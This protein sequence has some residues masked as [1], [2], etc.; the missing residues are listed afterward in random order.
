[1]KLLRIAFVLVA[2]AFAAVS[3]HAQY[4][5]YEGNL[6]GKFILGGGGKKVTLNLLGAVTLEQEHNT[7]GYLLLDGS[8]NIT[9]GKLEEEIDSTITEHTGLT[10]SYTFNGLNGCDGTLTVQSSGYHRTF[11]LSGTSLNPTTKDVGSFSLLPNGGNGE[12]EVYTAEK[13]V[14]PPGGCNAEMLDNV[15]FGG[16]IDGGTGG[17]T[18]KGRFRTTF[19]NTVSGATVSVTEID[20]V[21]GTLQPTAT[22]TYPAFVNFDCSVEIYSDTSYSNKIGEAQLGASPT[23]SATSEAIKPAISPAASPAVPW[24]S[25]YWEEREGKWGKGNYQD[26]IL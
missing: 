26:W 20:I 12:D 17:N 5:C 23:S 3:A 6:N 10:G 13:S 15:S 25:M 9:D 11:D 19:H 14:D 16:T 24:N 22:K 7:A 1:M 4:S 8:G 18:T 21:N 2:A